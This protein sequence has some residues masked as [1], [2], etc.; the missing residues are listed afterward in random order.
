MSV[1]WEAGQHSSCQFYLQ[2]IEPQFQRPKANS[3]KQVQS[4]FKFGQNPNDE[5]GEISEDKKEEVVED[6]ESTINFVL[7]EEPLGN[8][9]PTK[10]KFNFP[11]LVNIQINAELIKIKEQT[12][13]LMKIPLHYETPDKFEPYIHYPTISSAQVSPK[14]GVMQHKSILKTRSTKVSI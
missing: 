2:I 7:G 4:Q 6:S 3:H 12:K 10:V 14:S 5:R 13:D 1:F 9:S 11:E 8:R